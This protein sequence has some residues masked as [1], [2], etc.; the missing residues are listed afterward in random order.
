LGDADHAWLVQTLISLW[1]N[2][3]W[4]C[5][6]YMATIASAD[7]ELID[8]VHVDGGGR[9]RTIW[10]VIV[11][12][13]IPTYLVLLLLG[14]SN[15]LKNGF[16][17]YFMF[18]NPM[19]ADKVEVLDYYVYKIGFLVSDYPYSITLC[20]LQTILSVMLL[21]FVNRLARRTRGESLI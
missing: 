20:M 14:I 11:P 3:G 16:D 6:I 15:V 4:G 10:H 7:S 1:K 8:A 19:V 13:I 17:Q 18:Y 12:T 5:I 21:F 9:F 2:T